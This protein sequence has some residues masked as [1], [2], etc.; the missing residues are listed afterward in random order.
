MKRLVLLLSLLLLLLL[1]ACASPAPEAEGAFPPAAEAEESHP[2]E[3]EA[4]ASP[5]PEQEAEA[6][7]GPEAPEE[8]F[9]DLPED[10]ELWRLSDFLPEL[11]DG[12]AREERCAIGAGT[13]WENQ[14][15]LRHGPEPG[16]AIYI[17]GG[18]HGD[19]VA[20]WRAANLLKELCPRAGTVC[21][22]SPANR[23]G[24]EREERKT[25]SQRDLNRSFPGNEEGWDSERI[26][27]SI[28]SHIAE[29]RPDLVLDLHETRGPQESAPERDDLRNALIVQEVAPISELLWELTVEGDWNL[30]G[31]PPAGSV[32]RTVSL[33][34][35]IP[36]ITLE[37]WREEPLSL[38]VSRQL[39]AVRRVLA[40]YE[41]V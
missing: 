31:S 40:F 12:S 3:P 41:M 32:N 37:T 23:Y 38:R 9:P 6:A 39:E 34:L 18:I 30:L 21:V 7:R 27:A 36:V 14:V 19:E 22:L 33:E 13:E 15:V 11:C 20:G 4:E 5:S 8:L 1:P 17:I 28:Y 16:P 29:C 2:P 24:A 26:A 10:P 25:R 35:G